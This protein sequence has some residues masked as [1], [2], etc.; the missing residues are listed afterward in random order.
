MK[1]QP[2][3]NFIFQDQH[4][5]LKKK[6][7]NLVICMMEQVTTLNLHE[8]GSPQRQVESII[9][10][11]HDVIHAIHP[12]QSPPSS[13]EKKNPHQQ[14]SIECYPVTYIKIF[15]KMKGVSESHSVI[16]DSLQPHVLYSPRN[17]PGQ[18]TGAVTGSLLQDIFPTQGW[19]P[20]LLHCRQILYQ[21]SHQGSP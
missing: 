15:L 18:N 17:F 6:R 14:F 20:G 12:K 4:R 16:S 7:K 11:T 2:W 10:Y 8:Q 9:N 21:L 1:V 13:A 3:I 19:N 5:R